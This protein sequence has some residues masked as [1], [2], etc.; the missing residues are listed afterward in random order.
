MELA[1]NPKTTS[2]VLIDLQNSNVA[3]ELSPYP[4]R[5]VVKNAALLADKLR[6]KGGTVIFVQVNVADLLELPADRPFPRPSVISPH[7]SDIVPETGIRSGDLVVAK[8]QWGAFYG[9]ELEQHLRRRGIQTIILGGIATNFGV[10]S[11]ARGAADRG[12]ELVFAEDAMSAMSE[13]A[14]HF[15]IHTLFP[16]IGRVRTT[17][18]ILDA[19]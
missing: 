7:A 8:R 5:N 16:I 3:R 6:S 11:T 17:A 2:L 18:Q 1:L 4:A 12:F 10:E 13:E 14:H 19:I 9:T 15:T